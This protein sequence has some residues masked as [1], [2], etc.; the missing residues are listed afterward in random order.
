MELK[1]QVIKQSD[2]KIKAFSQITFDDDYI[3]KD[4]MPDVMKI[5]CASGKAELE[6]KRVVSEAVWLTGNIR[7]EVMY[8]SDGGGQLPEVIQGT[9][10]FQ[11]KVAVENVKEMDQLQVFFQVEDLSASIINSRKLAIRGL[12]N[13]ELLVEEVAQ[14]QIAY[15]FLDGEDCQVRMEEEEM[16]NLVTMQHDILRIHN[17]LNLPKTKPNI[18]KIICY[19]VDIRNKECEI[20]NH[21]LEMHGDAHICILYMSEEQQPEWF[22]EIMHFSGKVNCP[23]DEEPQ[24]YWVRSQL[25][26][27]KIE[28]EVDY[29][30]EM[31]QFSVEL[32]FDLNVKVWAED[33][34]SVMKDAYSLEKEL[35]PSY[36]MVTIWNYLVK[37]EAKYRVA[38]QMKLENGQE[39][40]LQICGYKSGVAIE[41]TK[42]L[43]QGIRVEGILSVDMLYITMDDGFPISHQLEQLP[44]EEILDVPDLKGDVKYELD[45]GVDQLQVN[46][47]DNSEYEIKATISIGA[48]VLQKREISVMESCEEEAFSENEGEQAGI[49][50]YIVQQEETLWDIA[51]K[52]HTTME[53]IIETNGMSVP[54]VKA[55]DRII[56]VLHS[57]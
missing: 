35:K 47:L 8:R 16:L 31:R 25:L 38:E 29:D 57:D 15:G 27:Q 30:K 36:Q 41:H 54:K 21:Q 18:G 22:D 7:F 32:A 9:I 14:T 56:I 45:C 53:D 17:E 34:I 44:F 11:E 46:L 28:A 13:V 43:E 2:E 1:K 6:E 55:G 19:Y 20:Q 3:V 40:I 49:V 10:P 37:N 52:Y 26:Q 5:I 23:M 51:K 48:L 39:K 4:H 12:M 24:L 42:V 33:T 50:G